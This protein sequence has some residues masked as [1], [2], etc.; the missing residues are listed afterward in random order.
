MCP[1]YAVTFVS[2]LDHH[3][4]Y[5][6]VPSP[7]KGCGKTTMFEIVKTFCWR[8]FTAANVS[9][10]TIYRMIQ[11]E[12]FTLLLDE[13]DTYLHLGEDLRGILN[14]GHAKSSARVVRC[15]GD[16]HEPTVF[17]T[18]CPKGFA[19]IGSL[20]PTLQDRSIAIPLKRKLP[21]QSVDWLDEQR[22]R[23][24]GSRIRQALR[25][26]AVDKASRPL[27][28]RPNLP[29][30]L[31]NRA[32]DN[33]RPLFSIAADAGAEWVERARVAA[34]CLAPSPEEDDDVLTMLLR[35]L[36]GIFRQHG[37]AL[38]TQ[39][40]VEH[41]IGDENRPWLEFDRAGAITASKL[42]G[43]LRP[44]G[45]RSQRFRSEDGNQRGYKAEWF[46]EVFRAYFPQAE[47][48]EQP[49]QGGDGGEE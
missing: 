4:P 26:W 21:G 1:V 48:P 32:A 19:L 7:T 35:D 40:I 23:D 47:Q 17:S 41:L 9:T 31:H 37:P 45:I 39:D 30:F 38:Y 16:D 28:L 27:T 24:M 13:G 11:R 25:R 36:R 14:S 34:E 10:A 18:W 42:S 20:P 3:T 49:E 43:L 44:L 2:G 46:T 15:V 29:E 22:L 6:G 12:P 33:W 5:L 8:G